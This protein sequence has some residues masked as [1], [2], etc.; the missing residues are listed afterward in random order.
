MNFDLFLRRTH[1]AWPR[2]MVVTLTPSNY[3]RPN[4][5]PEFLLSFNRNNFLHIHS[6]EL[7]RFLIKSFRVIDTDLLL[8]TWFLPSDVE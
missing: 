1:A 5:L 3:M 8:E 2:V 4:F 6:R 7:E